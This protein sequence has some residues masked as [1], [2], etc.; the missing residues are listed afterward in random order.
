MPSCSKW[1]LFGT[2]AFAGLACGR[3]EEN[4][5]S[6]E[7][8]KKHRKMANK[9]RRDQDATTFGSAATTTTTTTNVLGDATSALGNLFGVAMDT[10]S[11]GAK[12]AQ[13]A[14]E[15]KYHSC[16]TR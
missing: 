3:S 8:L 10:T 9:E 13:A 16:T 6:A 11:A 7:L 2:L 12:A 15:R 5:F 4:D 14:V 1:V